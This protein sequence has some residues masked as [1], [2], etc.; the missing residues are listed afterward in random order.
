MPE[1]TTTVS[2]I[3][4]ESENS[5]SPASRDIMRPPAPDNCPDYIRGCCPHGVLVEET[6]LYHTVKDAIDS[7]EMDLNLGTA[8]LKAQ[9]VPSFTQNSAN[10]LLE[11]ESV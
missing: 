2:K 8:V 5:S 1:F 10:S 7:A 6:A 9:T 11:T 4:A 3:A